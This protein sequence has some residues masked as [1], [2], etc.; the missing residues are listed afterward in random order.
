[1]S[2]AAL[3]GAKNIFARSGSFLPATTTRSSA[4]RTSS[5]LVFCAAREYKFKIYKYKKYLFSQGQSGLQGR[6]AANDLQGNGLLWPVCTPP[7]PPTP[8]PFL[9]TLLSFYSS[10]TRP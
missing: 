10:S 8:L 1:M 2:A 9:I 7:P 3:T 5:R 4:D 6:G